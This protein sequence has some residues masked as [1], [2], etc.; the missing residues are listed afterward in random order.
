MQVPEAVENN[1]NPLSW[2]DDVNDL[3]I[4]T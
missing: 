2:P 4:Q 3:C 1:P